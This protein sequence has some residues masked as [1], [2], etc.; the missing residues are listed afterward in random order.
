MGSSDL[1][2]MLLADSR[3][4]VGG[5]T[6]SGQLEPAMASGLTSADVPAFC[7]ARLRTVTLV[8][9]ATAV[10][11][12]AGAAPGAVEAEW[13]ARTP[14]DAMRATSRTLARGL[15][16]LAVR[17]WP[18]A[19]LPTLLRGVRPDAPPAGQLATSRAVVLGAIAAHV[20]IDPVR[21]ARLIAY[22]DV[23]TVVAAALK[24]APLDPADAT[25]W[26]VELMPDM[27]E[28]ADQVAGL[29]DPR[30]MPA[31]SAPQLELWAQQHA[32]TTRRLFSA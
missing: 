5:F 25:G 12:A 1:F 19:G 9:A 31:P 6:Q 20:G 21:L 2:V 23:Q 16:R 29:T 10:V 11:T 26:V 8:E 22:D 13:A 28:L 24:L 32:L 7:R 18:E 17:V 3:L 4:P 15:L 30:T 14:S 27:D